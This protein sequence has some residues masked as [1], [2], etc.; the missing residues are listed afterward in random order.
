MAYAVKLVKDAKYVSVLLMGEVSR[1]DL[2]NSRDEAN[3]ALT[4]NGWNRLYVEVTRGNPRLSVMEHFKF[5]SEHQS[6]FAAGVR[7]AL[8]HR[9]DELVDFRFI[10]T[11]AQNRGVIMK[12]FRDKIQALSWLLDS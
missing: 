1:N 7:M 4:A 5:T 2:E 6:S 11:V 10:E 12:L 3:L 9:P 8:V